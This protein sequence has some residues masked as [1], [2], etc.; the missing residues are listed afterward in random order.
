MTPCFNCG[1]YD[2][3]NKDTKNIALQSTT[4]G[5]ICPKCINYMARLLYTKKFMPRTGGKKNES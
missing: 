4:V 2:G 5:P 1:T 3:K